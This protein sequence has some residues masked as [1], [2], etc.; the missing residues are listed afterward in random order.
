MNNQMEIDSES[1]A[2]DDQSNIEGDFYCVRKEIRSKKNKSCVHENDQSNRVEV[3]FAITNTKDLFIIFE[4]K[5][6]D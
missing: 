6:T 2:A 3:I 4:I 1:D 5:E